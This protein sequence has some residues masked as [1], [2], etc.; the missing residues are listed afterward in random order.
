MQYNIRQLLFTIFL[1]CITLVI[2]NRPIKYVLVSNSPYFIGTLCDPW[3]H[4]MWL[5]YYDSSYTFDI[6]ISGPLIGIIVTF[7]WIICILLQISII[8]T[9]FGILYEF[10]KEYCT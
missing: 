10:Y 5:M 2:L 6:L 4:I 3:R 1:I 7:Y 8:L 9:L